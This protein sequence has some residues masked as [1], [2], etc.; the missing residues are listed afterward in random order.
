MFD[1]MYLAVLAPAV[2]LTVV[3]GWLGWSVI[4]ATGAVAFSTA[5][6]DRLHLPLLAALLLLGAAVE[7][8][9]VLIRRRS[10]L[11]EQLIGRAVIS[12]GTQLS[13]GSLF[14]P[15]LAGSIWWL[16]LGRFLWNQPAEAI[17]REF[18]MV[19]ERAR[20]YL[21]RGIGALA[22]ALAILNLR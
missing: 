21:W 7:A 2:L 20:L 8:A 14:H 15:L 3:R 10:G 1:L 22:A 6:P 4:L 9:G 18:S 19:K 12:G 5:E 17:T 11:P 16:A 13:L